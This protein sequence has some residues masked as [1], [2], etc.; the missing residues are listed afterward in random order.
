M[1]RF[2][3]AAADLLFAQLTPAFELWPALLEKAFAKLVGGY[4]KLEGGDVGFAWQALTGMDGLNIGIDRF[5]A[6][7]P[8]SVLAEQFGFTVD[9][10]TRK[11]RALFAT[12]A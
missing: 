9:A 11:V 10:V 8:A 2:V 5:G 3:I 12:Q 1:I 7:A 4:P 6:S